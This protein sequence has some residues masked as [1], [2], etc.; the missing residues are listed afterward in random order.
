V[1]TPA[2]KRGAKAKRAGAAVAGTDK[3]VAAVKRA[4][5][6]TGASKSTKPARSRAAKRGSSAASSGKSRG[7]TAERGRCLVLGYDATESGRRAAAWAAN[8]LQPSGKLVLVYSERSLHAPASPLTS[9]QER[10]AVA[11][12]LFDELLL[13]GSDA[14]LDI[15]FTT[16]RSTKDPVTALI[17]AAKR[18]RAD[19]IVVGSEPHSR[20]RRMLGVV[21]DELLERS[22]VPVIAVPAGVKLKQSAARPR[23]AGRPR[24]Q[25]D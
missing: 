8:E 12:A 15:D 18:H 2:P 24:A 16:E 22:P 5:G 23:R 3:R 21:T 17:G 14:L 7:Q 20:L 13:E 25:S 10:N 1:S 9:A 6:K 11:G 19:A 4:A